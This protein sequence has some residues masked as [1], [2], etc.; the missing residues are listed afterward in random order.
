MKFP[1]GGYGPGY[2]VQFCTDTVSGVIVGVD[3][4][5]AGSIRTECGN[6]PRRHLFADEIQ[7]LQNASAGEV[8][9]DIVF[10]DRKDH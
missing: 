2:N 8:E 4:T 6:Y 9:I 7:P 3:V 5:N 1:N 10:E